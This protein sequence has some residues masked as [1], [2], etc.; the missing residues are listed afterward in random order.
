MS[1]L[2]PLLVALALGPG[3]DVE[4]IRPA[5]LPTA[6]PAALDRL[7]VH[8][9]TIEQGDEVW[10]LFGHN[11]LVIRDRE[12]GE[13][14]AWNWGLF[15][16]E[17]V[18]FVPRFLRGT[19]LYWMGGMD[20]DWMIEGYARA[21][22]TVYSHQVLL[23]ADE[24]RALDEF[25]QWHALPD[26]R[27]YV[28]DY[29]RDNCS[30]RIRDAL[31]LALGG[32][33]REH[34]LNRETPHSYRWH[35][36]R[37]VQV[38]G[39]VDQGLSFLLGTRGDLPRTEWEAMFI[40]MEMA[41][42]LEDFERPGEDGTL[43]PLLG[44]RQVL[45]QADR[46]PTPEAAPGFSLRF[47]L[48]GFLGAG[49]LVLLGWWA[50][51]GSLGARAVFAGA[52]GAWTLLTGLLGLILVSSWFTDHV[53][54]HW[55]LNLFY[56]NP[57]ALAALAFL[58]PALTSRRRA[59]GAPGRWAAG[60]ALAVAGLSVLMALLQALTVLRQG[61]GEVIAVALPLNLA[62]AL[63]VMRIHRDARQER[64]EVPPDPAY[65]AA[66]AA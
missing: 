29:F 12:T 28:Y 37:L 59:G 46:A 18:D 25:V 60:L 39:W 34:F 19:M 50:A 47:P 40:P 64:E 42:L 8:L 58:L 30:T 21:N 15:D 45:F 55:N 48:V 44:P 43:Q 57:L 62:L 52:A 26:N 51:G 66:A 13:S 32:V 65:A 56:A 36:R 6:A 9:V 61:N 20:P 27:H 16:F 35:S 23:T 14:V 10:E 1:A 53:F 24:A 11:A 22:R 5:G 63:A 41:E 3:S 17:D 7:E 2:L 31:D 54:I 38:T 33:L 49:L 4:G